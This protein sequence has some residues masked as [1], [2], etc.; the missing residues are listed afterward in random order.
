MAKSKN[1]QVTNMVDMPLAEQI[2]E[3]A[4]RARKHLVDELTD[5][6]SEQKYK[7]F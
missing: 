5:N 3:Y 6:D 1:K 4:A 2:D 7:T